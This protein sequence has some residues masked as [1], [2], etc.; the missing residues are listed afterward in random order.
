MPLLLLYPDQIK[1]SL[2]IRTI[3]IQRKG[4][5]QMNTAENVYYP[6]TDNLTIKTQPVVDVNPIAKLVSIYLSNYKIIW[7]HAIPFN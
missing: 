1:R 3:P 7:C 2:S 4:Q 6:S 5:T